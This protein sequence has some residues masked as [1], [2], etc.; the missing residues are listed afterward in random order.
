MDK[1]KDFLFEPG[2]V[3]TP[4][5]AA[6]GWLTWTAAK[7]ALEAFVLIATAV[8]VACHATTAITRRW[9]P[10]RR[11][12]ECGNCP[13]KTSFFCPRGLDKDDDDLI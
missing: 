9:C 2:P 8:I 3:K 4:F 7:G 10:K 12:G 11:L 6:S 1:I 13:L 5:F